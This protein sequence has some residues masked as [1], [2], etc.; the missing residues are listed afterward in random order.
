M[1][2]LVKDN[3]EV[4]T[5]KFKTIQDA[6]QVA[7]AALKYGTVEFFWFRK[8]NGILMLGKVTRDEVTFSDLIKFHHDYFFPQ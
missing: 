5:T 6:V 2:E 8:E 3:Y 4:V 1:F 7:I